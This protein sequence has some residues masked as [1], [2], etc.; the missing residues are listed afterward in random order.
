MKWKDGLVGVL[1]GAA[2]LIATPAA[3]QA[4]G[5]PPPPPNYQAG[6]P[7]PWEAPPPEFR[8]IARRGFHD[9]I[10][11]ARR[12]YGNHRPPNVNNRDEFRR[13]PVQ[14]H[15]WR[16]YRKAFRRGYQVGVEHIYGG[17]PRRY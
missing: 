10:E 16:D 1:F 6:P 8:D 7:Q 3:I 14:R 17:G 13:P 11:G 4:Q 5:P 9:G 12:D 15:A 2:I